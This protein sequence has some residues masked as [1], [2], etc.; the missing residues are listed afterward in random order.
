M[1][2]SILILAA[3]V[4]VSV[5]G[6]AF[7]DPADKPVQTPVAA[8]I[9][10]TLKTA[11]DQI[12][13]FAFDGNTDT[14]FA[15]E[16]E[17]RGADH[18]TLRF[19]EL[20]SLK[21]FGV[22]TGR[23]DGTDRLTTGTLEISTDGLSFD[24]VAF[25]ATGDASVKLDGR[26]VRAI[27]IN[28]KTNLQHPLVI[29]EF[30]IKSEPPVELFRYPVEILV[31]VA[32]AP[33]MKDWADNVARICERAYPLINDELKSDGFTP[34]QVITM[35]LKKDYNGVAATSGSHIVGSVKFF[36][37]HPDDVGAMVHETAHV[38]Q[39]Y[40][41]RDNPGWL[42]EGVA[43]YVRF[44]KF[45]PG[46]LGRIDPDRSHYNGSYRVTAAFLAYLVEKHDPQIVLK[47]NKVM[48]DGKYTEAIFEQLT[49]K[50]LRELDDDWRKTLKPRP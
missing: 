25:F 39:Q 15:S 12:R 44:F 32:D 37:D 31:N 16:T 5:S 8:T 24:S 27:R 23:L 33:E 14:F 7:G 4:F 42:V 28:P 34:Q 20:V 36:Q 22:S 30:K 49:G 11:A 41:S 29:R 47:L 48:R 50:T 18:F 17:V 45:E 38:V 10:T 6:V 3:A 19:D 13:Q 26:K 40:R 46:K 1:R 2:I 35:T 9:D 21:W 43:D